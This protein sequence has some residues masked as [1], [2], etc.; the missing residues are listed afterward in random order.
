M[1]CDFLTGDDGNDAGELL[2]LGYIDTLDSRVCVDAARHRHVQHAGQDDVIDVRR[3]ARHQSRIFF[4]LHG[5][6][7]K[8]LSHG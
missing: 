3:G 8:T 5:L 2:C 6:T 1:R 7:D 4:S